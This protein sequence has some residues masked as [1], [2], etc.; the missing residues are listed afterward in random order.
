[1]P[2]QVYPTNILE[3]Q[4]ADLKKIPP[5][6]VQSFETE[7]KGKRTGASILGWMRQHWVLTTGGVI[8]AYGIGY[9]LLGTKSTTSTEE[10]PGRPVAERTVKEGELPGPMARPVEFTRALASKVYQTPMHSEISFK[11]SG[12]NITGGS[13]INRYA[14]GSKGEITGGLIEGDSAKISWR[15]GEYTGTADLVRTASGF[16]LKVPWE[17]KTTTFRATAK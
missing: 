12:K 6:P 13:L 7:K 4:L 14:K 17:G 11:V 1:M 2:R 15:D 3:D 5:R 9:S 10:K 16:D 8:V